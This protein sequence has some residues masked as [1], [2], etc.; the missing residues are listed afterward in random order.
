LR[1]IAGFARR[2]RAVFRVELDN[3]WGGAGADDPFYRDNAFACGAG[4][5]S[6]VISATGEVMPCT[7]TDVGVSQGNVR[8]R[9]LSDIWAQEFAPFRAGSGVEGDCDDC[10]L[11]TRHGHSCRPAYTLDLFEPDGR[12]LIPLVQV[13][14][15][16]GVLS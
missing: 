12:R 2:L 6:C 1:R 7:T 14:A 10:W 3:E 16:E 11:N 4:R 5:V 13:R 9:R 8:D 15:G